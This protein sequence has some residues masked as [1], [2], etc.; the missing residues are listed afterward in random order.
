MAISTPWSVTCIAAM[1]PSTGMPNEQRHAL[2]RLRAAA[3]VHSAAQLSHVSA[4]RSNL[5]VRSVRQLSMSAPDSGASRS[6][7]NW[8]SLRT[9]KA[10]VSLCALPSS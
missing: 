9:G 2:T 1:I 7:A 10:M 5:A 4:Q 3:L 8:S 6:R